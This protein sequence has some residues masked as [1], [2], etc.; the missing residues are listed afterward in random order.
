M[1]ISDLAA[2]LT[3]SESDTLDFKRK[4]YPFSGASKQEKS[5]LLKDILS[6][7]NVVKDSDRYVVIGV[8]EEDGRVKHIC[9]ADTTLSDSESDSS[10]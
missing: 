8:E 9:G 1:N 7:A 10:S 4:Q 6:F 5:E 2:L 3:Q